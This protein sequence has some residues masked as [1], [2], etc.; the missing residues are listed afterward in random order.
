MM[1]DKLLTEAR[2]HVGLEK[3]EEERG[4]RGDEERAPTGERLSRRAA[5]VNHCLRALANTLRDGLVNVRAEALTELA[6]ERRSSPT[7]RTIGEVHLDARPIFGRQL[8][9]MITGEIIEPFLIAAGHE[10]LLSP[11]LR[12]VRGPRGA[13]GRGVSE[14]FQRGSLVPERS[15]RS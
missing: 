12:A 15:L 7:R 9:I 11:L 2:L 13:R 4:R 6:E 1:R 14:P 3:E 8:A 5:R 10:L